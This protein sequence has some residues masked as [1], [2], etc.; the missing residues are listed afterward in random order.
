MAAA[1]SAGDRRYSRRR[2]RSSAARLKATAAPNGTRDAA[3]DAAIGLSG[4]EAAA[5]FSRSLVQLRKIDP[6]TVA[7]EKRRVIARERVLEWFDP[8]PGGLDMVGGLENLK[9]WL[10]SRSAAYS[11][12]AR[13]YGLPAPK[14]AMLVGIPGCGKSLTAKAIATAWGCR[15]SRST[16]AR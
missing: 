3:I 2:A 15:C 11:P 16:S 10:L 6:A 14:G 13:A 8:L 5:C 7:K 9:A 1:R 12:K 4:E